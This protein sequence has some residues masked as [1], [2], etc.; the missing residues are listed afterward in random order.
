[1]HKG[2]RRAPSDLSRF[3]TRRVLCKQH[4]PYCVKPTRARLKRSN[5]SN[6]AS[7]LSG[8]SEPK[9]FGRLRNIALTPVDTKTL[10]AGRS[11]SA[12]SAMCRL[13]SGSL[14]R[15]CW[16][17]ERKALSANGGKTTGL[18]QPLHHHLDGYH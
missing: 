5:A 15:Q 11:I 10:A 6:A 3:D 9:R 7:I 14:L 1:M 17:E 8:S 16:P 13:E 4:G 2:I 18:K 12:W